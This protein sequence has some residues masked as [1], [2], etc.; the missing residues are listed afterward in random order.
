M[1]DTDL[2]EALVAHLRSWVGA[3]PAQTPPLVVGNPRNDEPGWDGAVRPVVGVVDGEGRTVVGVPPALAAQANAAPFAD[4]AALERDLPAR[5][6]LPEHRVFRGVF[7]WSVTPA[8]LPDAGVWLP[9]DDERVPPWL[10]PFGGEV[11]V[12]LEDDVYVAGVGVK[13]HDAYGHELAVVTEERARGNGLARKLVAQAARRVV[14]EGA[15]ATY[16]HAPDNIG[17][18]KVAEASG[19]PDRG[20]S[21]LGMFR[22]SDGPT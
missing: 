13:K 5:L 17:S 1:S 14:D 18:A 7:R 11:L 19:F 22:P 21:I 8:D 16:L 6:G 9:V 20:W 3:W 2:P 12:A 4:L 15:V 10:Q